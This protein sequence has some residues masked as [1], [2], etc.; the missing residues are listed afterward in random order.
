[1]VESAASTSFSSGALVDVVVAN[2]AVGNREGDFHVHLLGFDR[3]GGM[4]IIS[5]FAEGLER[6]LI[7]AKRLH[8]QTS[9]F[10]KVS[11]TGCSKV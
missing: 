5:A 7:V 10:V 4:R 8:S 3:L 11:R 2:F 9:M 1:M 6:A